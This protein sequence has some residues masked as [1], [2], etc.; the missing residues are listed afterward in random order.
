MV[1]NQFTVD[2]P[3]TL[4]RAV[5]P[6]RAGELK[7][8]VRREAVQDDRLQR[9][10]RHAKINGVPAVVVLADGGGEFDLN[11]EIPLVLEIQRETILLHAHMPLGIFREFGKRDGS[12]KQIKR[13]ALRVVHMRD[14][15]ERE[16]RAVAD[17][18]AGEFEIGQGHGC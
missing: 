12:R 4:G 11:G 5:G 9:A 14:G 17:E 1:Q 6:R 18:I 10:G 16:V 2:G 8:R 15:G 7:L 3:H 13:T